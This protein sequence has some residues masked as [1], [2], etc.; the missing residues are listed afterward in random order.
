MNQQTIKHFLKCLG[1]HQTKSTVKFVQASCP[2]AFAKHRSGKD[3]R[4]SFGVAIED[5]GRSFYYCFGCNSSGS[6]DDLLVELLH[7]SHSYPQPNDMHL[8]AAFDLLSDEPS[9]YY[10]D[11]D[12]PDA[13]PM[14]VPWPEWWLSSFRQAGLVPMARHYLVARG[15]GPKLISEFDIRYDT[16]RDA[17]CFPLRAGSGELAGMRGRYLIPKADG[18]R[19]HDYDYQGKRNSNLF[20]FNAYR[21]DWSKPVVVVEGVFDAVAVYR[22]YRNVISG[23]SAGLSV[24]RISELAS[25]LEII[26]FFDYD[27]AGKNAY[28]KVAKYISDSTVVRTVDWPQVVGDTDEKWD[29]SRLP[30]SAVATLLEPLVSL[31]EQFE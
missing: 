1:I 20:W 16:M 11:L 18:T 31:D 29:A 2:L 8:A 19:Y 25:A 23:L 4:P 17:V 27:E 13:K 26:C 9:Y 24:E 3:S 6:L 14:V 5:N 15:I 28:E 21:I 22:W 10:K 7:L 30:S 12:Q